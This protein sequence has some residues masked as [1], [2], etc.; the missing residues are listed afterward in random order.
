VDR[1]RRA[2]VI[3][4]VLFIIGTVGALAASSLGSST[5]SSDYLTSVA[6]H[7]SAVKVAAVLQV[8]AAVAI[9]LIPAILFPI[10]RRHDEGVALGYLAIRVVESVILLLGALASLLL[11]TLSEK[12]V[13]AGSPSDPSYQISGAILQGVSTWTFVLDPIVFG[14]GALLFYQLL[15]RTRL[16]PLWLALWGLLGAILVVGAGLT[17]LFGAFEFAL[18]VPIAIQEMALAAWLILKGFRPVPAPH[19]QAQWA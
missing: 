1:D 4:G 12:F 17:G 5:S 7:A 13:N 14:V 18:A 15:A 11:I 3:V 16:V 6:A 9:A 10:L 19:G 2:A 8:S